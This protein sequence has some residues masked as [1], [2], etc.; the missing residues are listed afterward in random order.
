M[1]PKSAQ[2]SIPAA[3]SSPSYTG[4]DVLAK[5]INFY[6]IAGAHLLFHVLLTWL[7]DPAAVI[8]PALDIEALIASR[9]SYMLYSA[10]SLISALTL[11]LVQ[12]GIISF[13]ARSTATPLIKPLALAPFVAASISWAATLSTLKLVA[14]VPED[15]YDNYLGMSQ[16]FGAL[17]AKVTQ[18]LLFVV[19]AAAA[20]GLY[21][22]AFAIG[23]DKRQVTGYEKKRR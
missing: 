1:T 6:P 4:L 20:W 12:S 21:G 22:W 17:N 11:A 18:W 23:R 9:T 14:L 16:K 2:G 19:V 8:S 13:A 3:T 10:I 7:L 15:G 5:P